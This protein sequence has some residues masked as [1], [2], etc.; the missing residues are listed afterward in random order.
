MALTNNIVLGSSSF[1]ESSVISLPPSPSVPNGRLTLIPGQPRDQKVCT[2]P[3]LNAAGEIDTQGKPSPTSFK[4]NPNQSCNTDNQVVRLKD[5][6][7]LAV[8]NG[9]TWAAFNSNSPPWANEIIRNNADVKCQ[10]GAELFFRSVDGGQTWNYWSEIDYGT[11]LGGIYGFPRPMDKDGHADVD[12]SKQGKYPDG[13]L[14]WWIGG[15]DREEMY[16]CPFTGNL[17]LSTRVHSGPYK[18]VAVRNEYLLLCSHDMGKSWSRMAGTFPSWEPMLITSTPNGRLYILQ[19]WPDTSGADQPFVYASNSPVEPGQVPVMGPHHQVNY[20]ENGKPIPMRTDTQCVITPLNPP[21][22]GQTSGGIGTPSLS[23]ISADKSSSKIRIAYPVINENERQE[24]RVIRVEF[25][26]DP[27]QAPAV[28]PVRAVAAEDPKNYS[29][30]FPSIID[31]DYV[32]MPGD[33]PSNLSLL[34]WVEFPKADVTPAK[35]SARYLTLNGDYRSGCPTYLSVANGLPRTWADAQATGDYVK[36]S[37][38]W[39][40][41]ALNFVP[42]WVEPDGVKT[43]VVTVPYSEPAG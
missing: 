15:G 21:P 18:N 41:N 20:I 16:A 40:S 42:Q 24:I 14:M 30:C 36:G 9:S 33:K 11:F 31:P 17:Y 10:R 38:F 34:F 32:D 37:F 19:K 26:A 39:H 6:S 8:R 5:G 28:A 3:L 29:A 22:K 13:N 2:R 27:A 12:P 43:N 23:R 7:I 1:W 25:G 4:P 35:C